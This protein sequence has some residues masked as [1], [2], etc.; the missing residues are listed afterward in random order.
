MLHNQSVVL[1]AVEASH[2]SCG[3]PVETD[4]AELAGTWLQYLVSASKDVVCCHSISR[5]RGT[6]APSDRQYCI[7]GEGE[8]EWNTRKYGGLK[9]H[10][11]RKIHIGIE[12]QTLEIHTIEAM[13]SNIGDAPIFPD[14]FNQT[15]PDEEI[16]SV[17]ADGAYDT[18][19]CHDAIVA[20]NAH[21]G[22]S[23]RKNVQLWKP[24]TPGA[25]A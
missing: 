11:W 23:P 9:R 10:L 21:A 14:L 1:C 12:E 25:M 24:D 17:T 4:L 3:K 2:R 18:R 15:P 22:I 19:K 7:K 13:N 5:S 8:G 6:A 20:R 16:I